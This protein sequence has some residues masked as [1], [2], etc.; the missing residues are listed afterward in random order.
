MGNPA[1]L[2]ENNISWYCRNNVI[3]NMIGETFL[4]DQVSQTPS[5]VYL[6]RLAH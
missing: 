2:Q 6:L 4:T 1:P 3:M 5:I